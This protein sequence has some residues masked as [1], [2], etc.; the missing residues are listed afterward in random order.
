MS[1]CLHRL[2]WAPLILGWHLFTVWAT[3]WC[4]PVLHFSVAWESTPYAVCPFLHLTNLP[5]LH[6]AHC[7]Q[8]WEEHNS[9]FFFF[10][11]FLEVLVLF[12]LG[13]I[14]A[15]EP[16]APSVLSLAHMSM[17][18]NTFKISWFIFLSR[19]QILFNGSM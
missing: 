11:H 7:V 6:N 14:H 10:G 18:T 8:K 5:L 4:P 12:W 17:Q 13:N 2:P 1:N 15:E 3:K 9:E 16:C 19:N